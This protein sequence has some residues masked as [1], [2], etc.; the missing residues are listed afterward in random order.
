MKA[1]TYNIKQK[2]LIHDSRKGIHEKGF[3]LIEAIV[4]TAVFAF[5]IV[6][7]M[8]VFI[9]TISLDAKTRAQRAVTQN[10]RFIM[11]YLAKE[12]RNGTIYYSGY[13]GGTADSTLYVINQSDEIE[14]FY[15]SGT[16]LKLDKGSS[17]NLNTAT[18]RV[19]KLSFLVYPPENPLT[20]AKTYDVQ[21]S[22]TVILELSSN[23][24][25]KAGETSI[26]NLQS[27]FTSRDYTSRQ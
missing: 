5:V 18:V 19:T 16:D 23:Y 8:G 20:S 15:L 10:A 21:P 9:A 4:A 22:V 24:G 14:H 11:E 17:T 27:T 12:V 7:V 25:N 26:I 6:S 1:E 13:P 3:T 2:N